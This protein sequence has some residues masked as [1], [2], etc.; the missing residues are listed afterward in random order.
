MRIMTLY[1]V[2]VDDSSTVVN[3]P[4]TVKTIRDAFVFFMTGIATTAINI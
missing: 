2:F 1:A 3:T 4:M